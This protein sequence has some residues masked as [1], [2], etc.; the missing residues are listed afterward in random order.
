MCAM[1]GEDEEPER[2]LKHVTF[3]FLKSRFDLPESIRDL[4]S[5]QWNILRWQNVNVTLPVLIPK[6]II[7][8][9]DTS[10]SYIFPGSAVSE[11]FL[12]SKA[13]GLC[14]VWA[15]RLRVRL[16]VIHK[17]PLVFIPRVAK[18][19]SDTFKDFGSCGTPLR[20][21]AHAISRHLIFSRNNQSA[22]RYDTEICC[23][24]DE[25]CVLLLS[26][27]DALGRLQRAIHD[28]IREDTRMLKECVR[29]LG[30]N[31]DMETDGDV[32]FRFPPCEKMK[33]V[34][35]EGAPVCAW[36][37]DD[38]IVGGVGNMSPFAS[39]FVADGLFA[40]EVRLEKERRGAVDADPLFS[41]S[42]RAVHSFSLWRSAP[43]KDARH[44]FCKDYKKYIPRVQP[45]P[46]GDILAV[47][48]KLFNCDY[49]LFE[50]VLG[51][52]VNLLTGKMELDMPPLDLDFLKSV[53]DMLH[54]PMDEILDP[55]LTLDT[56]Q[57]P[58][59]NEAEAY[60]V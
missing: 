39:Q 10:N 26:L 46:N 56:T 34:L 13:A 44:V 25:D 29:F 12:F 31:T 47:G 37:E 36:D 53:L 21:T 5:L 16:A 17:C 55:K 52:Q 9:N 20:L 32:E 33:M 45:S 28:V 18:M 22:N 7:L 14:D 42:R 23:A 1:R 4:H 50:K 54:L 59:S 19:F 2:P 6:G 35:R 58:Q 49:S 38:S 3:R 30:G 57:L 60:F 40:T 48:A 27:K 15:S 43:R 41:E 8:C 51:R 11:L 24:S